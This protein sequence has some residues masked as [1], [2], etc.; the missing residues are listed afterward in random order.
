MG[1]TTI[2]YTK[3]GARSTSFIQ[4]TLTLVESVELAHSLKAYTNAGISRVGFTVA[5]NSEIEPETPGVDFDALSFIALIFF[6]DQDNNLVKLCIPAPIREQYD[7]K[8]KNLKLKKTHGDA[9][10]AILGDKIGKTLKF[11]HG[12]VTSSGE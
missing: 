3:R 2:E 11:V 12:G 9:L 8:G 4:G 5:E 10:A 1:A 6:R 7:V